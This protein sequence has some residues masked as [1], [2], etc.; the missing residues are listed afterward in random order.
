MPDAGAAPPGQQTMIQMGL[1]SLATLPDQTDGQKASATA[2]FTHPQATGQSIQ[3]NLK[4]AR[5]S[6][7]DAIKKNNSAQNDTLAVTAVTL[8]GQLTV[9]DGKAQAASYAILS[10]DQQTK[11]ETLPP[12]GP[13]GPE[14][15]R[16]V[17]VW[18][19]R[20]RPSGY[21]GAVNP[22]TGSDPTLLPCSDPGGW[23]AGIAEPAALCL[24]ARSGSRKH[25]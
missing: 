10:A 19:P 4:E 2:I 5:Q 21:L 7:S 23:A 14:A 25:D 15:G 18:A 6:L 8:T 17:A 3:T 20:H 1:N 12:G 24:T 9:I 11:Y 13:G 16:G 22:V